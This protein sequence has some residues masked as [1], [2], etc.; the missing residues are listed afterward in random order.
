MSK[1]LQ[2]SE[3]KQALLEKYLRY[4]RSLTTATDN[5]RI[6][7]HPRDSALP[8][9]IGQQSLYF[10]SQLTPDV[11]V[12]NE[13]VT[14]H[15]RGSLD[16]TIFEQSFNE[17]LRR[18]EEWRT[19]FPI[20]NEQPVQ[21][22]NVY[23][24]L[25]SPVVDLM[26]L[27]EA[28]RETEALR[29]AA[30]DAEQPF[31]FTHGPLLRTLLV[32]F[33]NQDTRLFLTMHHLIFDGF[34]LYQI[35]LPELHEIYEAFLEGRP[36]PL[37]ELPIQY[38]DFAAW[39]QKALQEDRLSSHMAYWKEQL[40]DIPTAL[41]LPTDRPRPQT[42]TSRGAMYPFALPKSL[43]DELKTLS[44]QENVT[45]FITMVA[46]LQTLLHRY[47]GQEDIL[48]GTAISDRRRPEV[49]KLLGFFLNTVVLRVNL[50]G[51][52]TFRDLLKQVRKIF[53]EAQAH[54]DVPFEYLVKEL[55]PE[56]TPGQNPLFQALL[57][58]EDTLPILPS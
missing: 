47:C 33:S 46:A 10:L 40:A 54:Q 51:D 37:P 52:P 41:E 57:V 48:L 9:S 19:C 8:L 7:R 12:Y 53:L 27:P 26:H 22:I 45:L 2:S 30:E 32:R 50:S 28:E 4:N 38:A 13:C 56:R 3:A 29:L 43:L 23:Q 55:Q 1:T 25:T 20:E 31:D 42:P 18:H 58:I 5:S 49:Q 44:L 6:P 14:L 35:L 16:F 17:I 36:S 24:P 21:R 15:L 34:S 39:Q 11:P